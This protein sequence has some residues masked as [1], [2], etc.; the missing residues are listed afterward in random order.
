MAT[1]SVQGPLKH[2][3]WKLLKLTWPLVAGSLP[4]E[5]GIVSVQGYVEIEMISIRNKDLDPRDALLE[6][7]LHV[8]CQSPRVCPS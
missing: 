2:A 1:V 6:A 3:N 7:V 8:R 5:M 4:G